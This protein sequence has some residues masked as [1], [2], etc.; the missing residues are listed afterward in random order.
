MSCSGFFEF[1]L[2]PD[3][4]AVLLRVWWIP[5]P[6][7]P[8]GHVCIPRY[9]KPV[10]DLNHGCSHRKSCNI[11]VVSGLAAGFCLAAGF[12]YSPFPLHLNQW[13]CLL[14]PRNGKFFNELQWV[15]RVSSRF[16]CLNFR[17]YSAALCLPH[18]LLRLGRALHV[19]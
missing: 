19:A 13:R 15:F 3:A 5:L 12:R 14:K 2:G 11:L 1:C 4:W 16:R 7:V 18:I 6:E 9:S 8:P 10:W 17:L